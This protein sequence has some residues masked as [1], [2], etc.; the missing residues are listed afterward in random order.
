MKIIYA[1]TA[2]LGSLCYSVE[3]IR[4]YNRFL[5]DTVTMLLKHDDVLVPWAK[6]TRK[7]CQDASHCL[8]YDF[9][10]GLV[11]LT[12]NQSLFAAFTLKPGWS[13]VR[14]G[15]GKKQY[16]ARAS[17]CLNETSLN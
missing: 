2:S 5:P 11:T 4:E 15:F 8:E 10:S 14:L 1:N 7:Q 13:Q 9:L 17:Q 3:V 6:P 16:T 12:A